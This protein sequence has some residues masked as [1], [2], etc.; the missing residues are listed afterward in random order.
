MVARA[1]ILVMFTVD[2]FFTGFSGSDQLAFLGLGLAALTVLMLMSIGLLQGIMILTAQAVGARDLTAI[3][4]IWRGG[5][6]MAGVLGCIVSLPGLVAERIFLIAGLEPGI[7]AAAAPVAFHFAWG[8][9]AMLF[10]IA[11]TYVLEGIGRPYVGMTI[12]VALNIANVFL[13]GIFVAG[14]GG[15]VEPMGAI[16]AT[17]TTSALRWCGFTAALLYI[18]RMRE[19]PTF[20]FDGPF[21]SAARNLAPRFL[22]LGAPMAVSQGLENGA[23]ATLVF[24]AGHIGATAL[25]AHQVT[26]NLVQLSFM[27]AVGMA[28]ATAVR[29]GRSVGAADRIGVEA[30][31][32]IGVGLA[33]CLM[34]PI[35][36]LL[37]FASRAVGSIF[38]QPGPALDVAEQTIH[39][40]GFSVV[41][42]GSMAVAMGALRGTGDTTL[43]MALYA[44]A[45]WVIAIPA[46]SHFAFD[47][48]YGAPGLIYGLIVGVASGLIMLCTRLYLVSRREPKRA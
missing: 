5:L 14:W 43:P 41:L 33:V 19:R 21:F 44:T 31:A 36:L 17:A 11:C 48:G 34:I 15:I 6:V 1:G 46:A 29:V 30:A 27:I 37:L 16:G 39:A 7:A 12:M 23:Y 45:F 8:A 32:W 18:M 4:S 28:A 38:I 24:M 22:R 40:A 47:L 2:T 25:A 35:G 9:V 42:S 10:Y 20:H 3:G 13:D 26:M